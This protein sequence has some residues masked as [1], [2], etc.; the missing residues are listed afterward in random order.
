MLRYKQSLSAAKSPSVRISF[1]DRIRK[2][3]GNIEIVAV[4]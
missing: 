3:Q 4:G 1:C 2:S